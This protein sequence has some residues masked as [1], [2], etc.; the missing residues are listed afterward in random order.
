NSGPGSVAVT[1]DGQP[2]SEYRYRPGQ[3]VPVVVTVSE[4]GK[5]RWG[6][7]ATARSDDGCLQ[8]GS[9]GV[10]PTE[11]R[12]QI[13]TDVAT[14]QGCSGSTIEFPGHNFPKSGGSGASFEMVWTA[15][16]EGFGPVRFA[17]A[18]NAANGN[19]E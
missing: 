1:I 15:P 14:P 12:V 7:Q 13:V 5:N 10:S 19:N 18:G 2:L 4:A 6:F 17:A 3:T 16:A 8:A 9:F 11:S